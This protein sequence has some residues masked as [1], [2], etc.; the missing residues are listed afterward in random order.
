MLG[1]LAVG[2]G[3][4]VALAGLLLLSP[5]RAVVG[6]LPRWALAATLAA[7][8]VLVP[9]ALL[10]GPAATLVLMTGWE[11]FFSSYSYAVERPSPDA[12]TAWADA[13]FFLLV[14]P[15]L[16][17]ADRGHW[18]RP[19]EREGS[20][21]ARC[22]KGA[23]LLTLQAATV[24]VPELSR[25]L[26][27]GS[28]WLPG[29]RYCLFV[30]LCVVGLC[31]AFCA[32]AGTASIQIGLL[33]LGGYRAPEGY[34]RPWRAV[35]PADFWRRWNMYVGAWL[36]RYVFIPVAYKLAR[37][38]RLSSAWRTVIAV[39]ATFVVSGVAHDAVWFAAPQSTGGALLGFALAGMAVS[40]FSW[41]WLRA[42]NAG[43][44]GRFPQLLSRVVSWH[45]LFATIWLLSFWAPNG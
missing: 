27:D 5:L 36:R 1:D 11:L 45:C 24:G 17:Y 23:L 31:R 35:S 26:I 7:G 18:L 15:A 34:D 25:A 13:L 19:D 32:Q 41:A 43:G 38:S 10:Q 8:F 40:L 12:R 3:Y 2:Y 14:N 21:L 22:G 44:Y 30:A 42:A 37:R 9:G 4:H 28:S 39:M 20:G 29:S 16:S 6:R 33:G